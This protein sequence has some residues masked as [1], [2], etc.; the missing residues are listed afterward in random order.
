MSNDQ[1]TAES[2]PEEG[3]SRPKATLIKK[4]PELPAAVPAEDGVE[5]DL[6]RK[7]VIVAKKPRKIVV[8][9]KAPGSR[10]AAPRPTGA[11]KPALRPRGA[12]K[13]GPLR[14]GPVGR[15][16]GVSAAPRPVADTTGPDGS[17][18][19]SGAAPADAAVPTTP[20]AVA[21]Q[22][23][24]P[25]VAV[26]TAE[27]AANAPKPAQPATPRP[28]PAAAVAAGPAAAPPT[29]PVAGPPL[30]AS[31]QRISSRGAPKPP[32]R[33]RVT[34]DE[35]AADA[36]NRREPPGSPASRR[37]TSPADRIRAAE[38]PLR[39]ISQAS[40]TGGIPNPAARRSDTRVGRIG[41]P[42]G[43]PRPMNR[44]P[45]G[46]P[47]G[48][49]PSGPGARGPGGPPRPRGPGDRGG[50]PTTTDTTA[51]EGKTVKKF[52]KTN[53]GRGRT[54]DSW[55]PEEHEEKLSSFA[56]KKEIPKTNPV[57]KS[58]DILETTTVSELARKLNLKASDL[59]A[60][61]MS[62]G[63]MVTI[64]QQID[65]DTA[66]LLAEEYGS[67]VK[68]VSLFDETVIEEE[69]AGEGDLRSRPPVV[70]IMGHVDHGKTKLLDAIRQANVVDAEAG[71][72]T[73]HI[74]AYGVDTARG[75]IVFLDTPGHEAF[76][77]MRARGAQVTDLV[78]LV[79]AADDGLMPQTV[80]AI[81]HAKAA[82]VPIIV[83][84]NKIDLPSA[85]PERVKRQLA[86][87]HELVPEEWGGATLYNELSALQNLGIDGLLESIT[88][89]AD[90]LNLQASYETRAVGK[91]VESQVDLGRGIV[92]TVL[93][94]KGTLKAGDSFVAGVFPGKIRTMYND[95]NEK[96]TS[97]TP[98]EPVQI[99]GLTGIPEAG[100]PFQATENER[101]ARQVGEK[102]QELKKAEEAQSVSK[103]TLDNLY[104]QISEGDVQELKV[105]IKADVHGSVEALSGA[106]EGLST[107][108]I[109]LNVIHAAAGAINKE[110]VALASA[111]NAIV[112]GFHIRPAPNAQALAAREKVEI[113]K[114]DI[115]YEV[116]DDIRK[117]MEGLLT[118][119]L[120]EETLGTAEV[121]EIFKYSR[122]GVIAGCL[123]QS[124]TVRRGA[125]AQVIRDG[126][127][128][129]R[130][131]VETLRRFKDDARE[132]E[133][134]FECGIRVEN[135][136]DIKVGDLIEVIQVTEIA[137]TLQKPTAP[138]QR[139][140][141]GATA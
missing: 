40:D 106:L 44:M 92:A 6:E 57:P 94:Q 121:R 103:V 133:T 51:T 136:N 86:E 88:L 42:S 68:V 58:V 56:R 20:T 48:P 70:T 21:S 75:R 135:Y 43:G 126:K 71:G 130:S 87:Q 14:T 5:T 52:F 113:R 35:N 59:I 22:P 83:A 10:S 90:L 82:G 26:E 122:T 140:R 85:D 1:P 132:V 9:R 12:P 134:G 131:R 127:P 38:E 65:A 19:S 84:I 13:P 105:V 53:K 47:S 33:Q 89:Q 15:V 117:A 115:I 36:Q 45:G 63:T 54:F 67:K 124:G 60:K 62:M 78:V 49:R 80:E 118:P 91:V 141:V 29:R 139:E 25:P 74:G 98:S 99:V 96:M 79:V 41:G 39:R 50:A 37:L 120:V 34:F 32:D 11:P 64:N 77:A 73:Q 28:A 55:G 104:E 109:K 129:Y 7:G 114:Y 31:D 101:S 4:K 27:S 17:K 112:I 8:K 102:R 30:A 116:I 66:T 18:L 46:R 125:V 76:T 69:K 72:I 107:A 137:K 24:T 123:V 108:E 128:V 93:V 23:A 138:G 111:S 119:D 97:A 95:R 3:K 61:L 16:S 110:D 100:D 2:A 81:N